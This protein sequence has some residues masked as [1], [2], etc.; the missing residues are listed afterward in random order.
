MVQIHGRL[1]T[2]VQYFPL[3]ALQVCLRGHGAGDKRIGRGQKPL[4]LHADRGRLHGQELPV[5]VHG[6]ELGGQNV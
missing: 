4:V 3:D 2:G 6:F 1:G 5:L